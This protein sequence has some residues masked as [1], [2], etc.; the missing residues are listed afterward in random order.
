MH[1]RA[2][3]STVAPVVLLIIILLRRLKKRD[4]GLKW[5]RACQSPAHVQQLNGA[6]ACFRSIHF[7]RALISALLIKFSICF[8]VNEVR[9]AGTKSHSGKKKNKKKIQ[10]E[11]EGSKREERVAERAQ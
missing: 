9:Q 7:D 6:R 1:E 3:H 4:K 11:S 5:V 8:I 2:I 10:R